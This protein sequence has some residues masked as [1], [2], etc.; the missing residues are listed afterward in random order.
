MLKKH[1]NRICTYFKVDYDPQFGSELAQAGDR[2]YKELSP[3]KWGLGPP[4]VY[5]FAWPSER[6]FLEFAFR[7]I[8]WQALGM[9]EWADNRQEHLKSIRTGLDA[10]G[11]VKL[12]RI[13][14]KVSAYLPLEMSH[15]ELCDLMFGSFLAPAAEWRD[16]WGDSVDPWLTL[17]GDRNGFKYVTTV[18]PMNTHQI[19][20]VFRQHKNLERFVEDKF[21]DTGVKE[22]H[23]RITASDC[24]FFDIDLSQTDVDA[25]SLDAFARD[26][27]A[28]AE[29]VAEWCVRRLRSQ[30]PSGGK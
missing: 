1:S 7:A 10:L 22:F 17:E 23:D 5:V 16:E 29:R 30:P 24:L 28:E 11:V 19:A 26:S 21:L 27:L 2:M 9:G 14:F 20:S 3:P 12:N 25:H 8:A 6:Y 4:S 15:Q 18:S 13:G